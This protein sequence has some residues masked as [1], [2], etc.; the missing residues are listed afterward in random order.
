MSSAVVLPWR[1]LGVLDR[2]E[3]GNGADDGEERKCLNNLNFLFGG[4]E[5][6]EES[7]IDKFD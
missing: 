2:T 1:A 4:R 5:V 7:R 3:R 6:R